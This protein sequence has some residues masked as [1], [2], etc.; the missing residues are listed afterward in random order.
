MNVTEHC[1]RVVVLHSIVREE[2]WI[3]LILYNHRHV[4]PQISSIHSTCIQQV[5]E[6]TQASFQGEE[7]AEENTVSTE[8]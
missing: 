3:M 4:F 8:M 1:R 6:S 7:K 2:K 5:V